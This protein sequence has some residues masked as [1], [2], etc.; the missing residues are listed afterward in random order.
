MRKTLFFL[1]ALMALPAL[2]YGGFHLGMADAVKKK[3]KKL[4]EKVAE[5]VAEKEEESE[6]KAIKQLYST[7]E[8]S[9]EGEDIT[10]FGSCL[11]SDYSH[12]QLTKDDWITMM[13]YLFEDIGN[14]QVSITNLKITVTGNSATASFHL[15]ITTAEEGVVQDEDNSPNPL[16]VL[17][18]LIKENGSWK[19]YGDQTPPT[20]YVYGGNDPL[21]T[22]PQLDHPADYGYTLLGSA[23][24]SETKTFS[25]SYNYYAVMVY[26]KN[27]VKI[28]ALQKSDAS[29]WS[30]V[31][32]SLNITNEGELLGAPDGV[33]ATVGTGEFFPYTNGCV[34][35]T[36]DGSSSI[37]VI[38]V[39]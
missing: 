14:I 4:D 11:S 2:V 36:S 18:Y 24:P 17:N 30:S 1:I 6:E 31:S 5:K 25:G 33:Y 26:F 7:L 27:V 16:G 29:Y 23:S 34:L 21:T 37:K 32:L 20:Y 28:D 9:M 15:K 38:V 22:Y 19:F 35:L 8:S 39:P 10:A 3:V 12:Q 13:E